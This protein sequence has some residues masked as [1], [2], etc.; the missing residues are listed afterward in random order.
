MFTSGSKI[1]TEKKVVEKTLT[2]QS[3]L[4]LSGV[5]RLF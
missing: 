4:I 5:S 3:Q 1:L 2:Q